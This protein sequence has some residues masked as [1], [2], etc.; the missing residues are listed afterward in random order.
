MTRFVKPIISMTLL[1]NLAQGSLFVVPFA[2][3]HL[4]KVVEYTHVNNQYLEEKFQN[5]Q[6]KNELEYKKEI[7][8]LQQDLEH[9]YQRIQELEIAKR[10]WF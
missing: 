8:K 6:L 4:Y 5:T 7:Q 3:Y 9:S 1:R 10:R 2:A